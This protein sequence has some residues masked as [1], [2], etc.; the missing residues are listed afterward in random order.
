MIIIGLLQAPPPTDPPA[1]LG[2]A[3]HLPL[4]HLQ[5]GLSLRALSAADV[6]SSPAPVTPC[7]SF[8]ETP[9]L[10][11]GELCLVPPSLQSCGVTEPRGSEQ[12]PPSLPPCSRASLPHYLSLLQSE[13]R[14][15]DFI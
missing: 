14:R 11:E 13:P 12:Q 15:S 7:V 9:S 1:L 10:H 4:K 5:G 8:L 2:T 3:W 6:L